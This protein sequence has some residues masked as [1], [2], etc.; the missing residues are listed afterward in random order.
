MVSSMSRLVSVIGLGY[1]GLPVAVAFARNG[2]PVVAFDID[3]RRIEELKGGHDR[4]CEVDA[5]ALNVKELGFTSDVQ[6]LRAADFRIVTVPTPIDASKQPDLEPLRKASASIGSVLKK[7]DIVVYEI[8]G[9]SRC[10]R[11]RLHTSAGKGVWSQMESRLQ[12][13][14]FP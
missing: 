3:K 12:C 14:L 4:T 8:H 11:R 1:V 10:H 5:S 2:H 7:G 13:R 6:E 9:L